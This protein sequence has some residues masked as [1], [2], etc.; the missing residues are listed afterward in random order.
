MHAAGCAVPL[1]FRT[2]INSSINKLGT[3]H[4]KISVRSLTFKKFR[5]NLLAKISAILGEGGSTNK[6]QRTWT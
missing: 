3:Y 4:E 6:R 2:V 5:S 1:D